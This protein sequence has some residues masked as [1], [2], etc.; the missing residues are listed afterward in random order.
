MMVIAGASIEERGYANRLLATGAT[1]GAV[2]R[3]A[4]GAQARPDMMTG[5]V[6]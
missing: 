4:V 6:R 5:I 2:V 1:V 3:R